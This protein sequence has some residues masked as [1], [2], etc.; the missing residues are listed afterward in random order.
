MCTHVHTFRASST[1]LYAAL[2]HAGGGF[3]ASKSCF[4]SGMCKLNQPPANLPMSLHSLSAAYFS[5]LE[6]KF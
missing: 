1:V 4:G 6:I 5:C 3:W 2:V